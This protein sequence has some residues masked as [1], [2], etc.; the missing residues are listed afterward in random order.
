VSPETDHDRFVNSEISTLAAE[1]GFV[2]RPQ[3]LDFG[4]DDRVIA[5][6]LS[7]GEL[8]RIGAGLYAQRVTHR[9]LTPTERHMVRCRAVATRLGGAAAF[10]HQSAALLHGL[11]IWGIDLDAVHVTRLDDGRGRRQSGVAHHVAGLSDDDVMEVNGL[12]VVRPAR[13]VWDL[14]VAEA[15]EHA[16]VTVDSALHQGAVTDDELRELAIRH[17]NWR[18][19]RHAKATLS[20][21]DAKAES[22]GETRCRFAFRRFGIPAPESQ[23]EVFDAGGRLVGRSDFGWRAFRHLAEFDGMLKYR[24]TRDD[25]EAAS[26]A[27]AAEKARE[28]AL[29]S[30]GWGMTRIVWAEL[31][32]P[33]RE[34]MIARLRNGLDRSRRLYVPLGT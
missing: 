25:P 24:S 1:N 13:A 12:L 21:S 6:L 7:S 5:E 17:G 33:A 28:D 2:T 14:A 9:A 19:A 22:P 26:R 20:L 4:F 31:A 15:T 32:L 8:E 18:R 34:R 3:I 11:A 10:S 23:L 16:L 27:L 30:L 29:R